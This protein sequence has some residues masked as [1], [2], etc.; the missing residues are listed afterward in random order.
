M[1]A[2]I[3]SFWSL[4]IVHEGVTARI[5]NKEIFLLV[6]L[7]LVA[8]GVFVFTRTMAAREQRMEVRI[9][10]IWYDQ[11]K[12]YIASG[13]I[14]KAIQAFRRSTAGTR[15]NQKYALALADALIAGNHDIEAHQLL[16]RLR[17][18]DPENAEINIYLARLTAKQGETSDAV[19]YYQNALY[20][21]WSGSQIDVRRRQLRVELIRFLLGHQE[22]NLA[23]PELLILETEIPDSAPSWIETAKLFTEAGDPQHAL[24]DYSEAV[25]LDSHNV[26]ALTGAGE[27][28]FQLGDY[29]KATQ[30]LKDSLDLNPQSEKARQLL[31]LAEMVLADD[32]L[33]PHLTAEERQR[34]VIPDFER[35]LRRL[36]SCL[37]QNSKSGTTAE[38]QSLKA[39]AL[40]MEPKLNQR[41]HLPDS[42]MVGAG[43]SLI[44]KMQKA[45]SDSCGEPSVLDQ[46]LILIGLQHNGA[47]P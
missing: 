16:L 33:A 26:E 37:N 45:A 42:D 15:Y 4:H 39:E 38:L 20:G 22:G 29:A 36:D 44:F 1:G 40:A 43:V 3:V 24:K 5:L 23:S 19:R 2:A 35:S 11:G 28:S 30:Y 27:T 13:K 12:Q 31:S 10:R 32:P 34:R 46:A 14:E 7:A 18:A 21:R 47:R 17:E 25:R 41:K 8:V 9:G 6:A